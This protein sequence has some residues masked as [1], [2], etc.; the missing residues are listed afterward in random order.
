MSETS[1]NVAQPALRRSYRPPVLVRYGAVRDLTQTGS[2]SQSES[3]SNSQSDMPCINDFK[4]HDSCFGIMSD[5]R[6]KENVVRVGTHPLGIGL[7]LF[8]YRQPWAAQWGQGRQFGVMADEVV[9]VLP[10][11]VIRGDDGY[12]RVDYAMLGIEHARVH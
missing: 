8:D 4:R 2:G 7:Y 12:R 10:Q 9:A 3:N 5:P 6:T 11:A 1:S